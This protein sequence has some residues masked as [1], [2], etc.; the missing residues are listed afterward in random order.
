MTRKL[1]FKTMIR[2][3]FTLLLYGSSHQ[4]HAVGGRQMD[5]AIQA[6]GKNK[7]EGK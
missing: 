6:K 4:F 5:G 3:Q 1:V 7:S 2:P